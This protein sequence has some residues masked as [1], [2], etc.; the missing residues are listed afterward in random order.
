[1]TLRTYENVDQRSD[2]WYALRCGV[3]TASVVD[4]LIAVR[5]PDAIEYDCSDCGAEVGFPC[6]S[7][8]KTKGSPAPIKT[9]HAPRIRLAEADTRRVL[10]VADDDTSRSVTATLVAERLAGWA[11]EAPLTHDMWRGV[12]VEPIAR[13]AYGEHWTPASEVGFMIRQE[14]D[15]TLGYSPDG[16]VGDEG[17][18]E[19]KAPRAKGQVLAVL[20][21]EVPAYNMAQIQA[22]LLV[23]GRKWLDYI[24]YV[25]GLPLWVKRVY[26]DPQ[27]FAAI[28]AACRRFERTADQMIADY[29]SKTAGLPATERFEPM[30]VELKLT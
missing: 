13:E 10:D 28:T 1:M 14:E 30:K 25:G 11:E 6:V 23:S 22:G 9:A 19:V 21:D 7:K 4:K 20:A 18:I 2:E 16:L 15:W 3:V 24:P 26:P 29:R 12:D 17:L 5:R 8:A 27:W